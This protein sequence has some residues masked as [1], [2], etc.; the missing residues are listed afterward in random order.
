MQSVLF[1]LIIERLK[2]SRQTSE[3]CLSEF[4]KQMVLCFT[5]S[6]NNLELYNTIEPFMDEL[7]LDCNIHFDMQLNKAMDTLSELSNYACI[8]GSQENN[9]TYY[10][11][12]EKINII[13]AS[14][15]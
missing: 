5:V 15:P 7:L 2:I 1:D 11:I 14:Y 13:K 6:K 10:N 9:I 12:I 8:F 4:S 3:K